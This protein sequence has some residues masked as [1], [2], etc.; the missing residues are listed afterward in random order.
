MRVGSDMAARGSP[1]SNHVL[2]TAGLPYAKEQCIREFS[3][4]DCVS[5]GDFNMGPC[6]GTEVHDVN[7]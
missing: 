7:K 1:F 5:V 6:R 4:H 2:G 3:C